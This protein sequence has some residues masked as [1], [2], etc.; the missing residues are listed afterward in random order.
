[1]LHGRG[2]GGLGCV[3]V[4]FLV[5][6]QAVADTL[7]RNMALGQP[8]S[9]PCDISNALLLH[10]APPF[11]EFLL[12][13]PQHTSS[14]IRVKAFTLLQTVN[15]SHVPFPLDQMTVSDLF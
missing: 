12:N 15:Q 13:P 7:C 9:N 4:H 10:L 1:V 6:E 2:V 8:C 5:V 14:L 3:G 11:V